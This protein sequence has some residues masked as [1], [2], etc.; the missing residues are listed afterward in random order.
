M[1]IEKQITG[2]RVVLKVTGR[3][4]ATW[5]EHFHKASQETIRD[6]HHHLRI[7]A[8]GLEYLSS[9][10]IRSLIRIQR[11]L[12]AVKGS[13]GIIH[14]STFVSDTLR[15]S[16][17]QLLIASDTEPSATTETVQPAGIP[18]PSMVQSIPG[19]RFESHPLAAQGLITVRGHGRWKPW[20]PVQDGDA[21]EIG[22]PVN[23][24]GLGIGAPGK[25]VGSAR[26]RFGEFI[27]A[28]GHLSWLPGD[29]ADTPDYLEQAEQFIP[30]LQVIQSLTGEGSFSHLLRFSPE[31]KGHF[32]NLSD[33]FLQVLQTTQSNAAALIA[34]VEVEGLV[35]AALSRSPGLIQTNDHPG[36]FP[37][38]R[39]WLGF[40]GERIHGQA[41]ALVV[42]FLSR[43]PAH[44]PFSQLS[45]LTSRPEISAH[46]HAVVL[47][48]RPLQQGVL[49]L[50]KSVGAVFEDNEPIGLLH[51]IEDDRPAIGLGQSA[52][53]RGACWCAPLKFSK[54]PLS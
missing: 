29:G 18:S 13:F 16:G 26:S 50:E 10:G 52:F 51:L 15:L 46:A 8:S 34:L 25:D 44:A 54:E 9:A 17:L 43:D 45:P 6:G 39:N 37:E 5:A 31:E 41:Q 14:P 30:S 35:G 4:D 24:F 3:L 22:F 11:E 48:Y 28:S 20:Q 53:V 36:D 40:C 33:L 2:N 21:V 12:T 23:V 32:L 49:E 27:A 47:P 1:N 7:D 19:I 38:I 42:A